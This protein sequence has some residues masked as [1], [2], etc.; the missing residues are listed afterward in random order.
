[1]S[2]NTKNYPSENVKISTINIQSI[3]S[4]EH[5]LHEYIINNAID[6]CVISEAWLKNNDQYMV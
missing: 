4:K 6:A 1:M 5:V 2:M 3:K